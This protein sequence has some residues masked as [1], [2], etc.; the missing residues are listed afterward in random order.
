MRNL[1]EI[2]RGNLLLLIDEYRDT[3]LKGKQHGS[4]TAF[5][6]HIEMNPVQVSQLQNGTAPMGDGLARQIEIKTGK[7]GVRNFV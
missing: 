3:V 4:M 7:E 2:R 6:R 1:N 5:A